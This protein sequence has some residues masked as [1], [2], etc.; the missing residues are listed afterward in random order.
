MNYGFIGVQIQMTQSGSS[1]KKDH[2]PEVNCVTSMTSP[3]E[4][5]LPLPPPPLP[6]P[7]N[8]PPPTDNNPGN[9]C[10]TISGGGAHPVLAH[11]A[12][13]PALMRNANPSQAEHQQMLQSHVYVQSSSQPSPLRHGSA[14][15]TS[16]KGPPSQCQRGHHNPDCASRSE[17]SYKQV[18]PPTVYCNSA[19]S[20]A[21]TQAVRV[22]CIP[23]AD[24]GKRNY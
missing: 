10:Q 24:M 15:T 16:S 23:C 1:G 20:P 13:S 5:A 12:S 8:P 7:N 9:C 4:Q 2:G 14:Y 21:N 17:M 22:I 18:A 3:Q 6:P 19:P 11:T